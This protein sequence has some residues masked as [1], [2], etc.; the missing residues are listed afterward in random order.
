MFIFH[1]E[2]R[3]TIR[4]FDQ[5][6]R[7]VSFR[8]S[9][10]QRSIVLVLIRTRQLSSCHFL[11]PRALLFRLFTAISSPGVSRNT[12]PAA[13]LDA[14]T[15]PCRLPCRVEPKHPLGPARGC[16]DHEQARHRGGERAVIRQPSANF[17]GRIVAMTIISLPVVLVNTLRAFFCYPGSSRWD[18]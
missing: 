4:A 1:D 17:A 14:Q 8:L 2:T 13:I 5:L 11:V 9:R 12:L 7:D 3:R 10:I 6:S 15:R 18:R 16:P